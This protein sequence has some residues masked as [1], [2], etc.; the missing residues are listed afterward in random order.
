MV[1]FGISW[2]QIHE[3][4]FEHRGIY[5]I[6]LTYGNYINTIWFAV[7]DTDKRWNES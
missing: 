7:L 5:Q 2:P 3:I 4:D 6:E 1:G